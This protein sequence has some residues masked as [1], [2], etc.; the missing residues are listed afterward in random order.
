MINKGILLE[1]K[2]HWLAA[3][4]ELKIWVHKVD[5]KFEERAMKID[6]DAL[7]LEALV[8]PD[9]PER[10]SFSPLEHR[11]MELSENLV[12]EKEAFQG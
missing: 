6:L 2:A 3:V 1:S 4:E 12:I 9:V 10:S 8:I 5:P 7:S 11:C